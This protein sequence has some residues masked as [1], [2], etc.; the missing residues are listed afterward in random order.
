MTRRSRRELERALDEIELASDNSQQDIDEV[1]LSEEQAA[2]IRK[3]D[4]YC[5]RRRD[6]AVTEP[7]VKDPELQRR[8]LEELDNEVSNALN[9]LPPGR[10]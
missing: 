9:D 8:A 2:A 5:S 6:Q 4:L 7:P 1:D 3:L 10:R